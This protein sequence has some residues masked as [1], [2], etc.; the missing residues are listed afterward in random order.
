MEIETIEEI[1]KKYNVTLFDRGKVASYTHENKSYAGIILNKHIIL[2]KFDDEE[3]R[4]IT[5]FHELGHSQ[6]QDPP[7]SDYLVEKLSWKCGLK[8]AKE[9]GYKFSRNA[10][11]WAANCLRTYYER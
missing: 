8:I 1:A 4:T 3:I 10:L 11:K 9:H 5:F 7:L 6:I 2:G